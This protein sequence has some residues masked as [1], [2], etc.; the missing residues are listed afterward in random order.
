MVLIA[1]AAA[2]QSALAAGKRGVL[3][4]E[5]TVEG[6][7][8]WK[9]GQ[10]WS[11][12]KIKERFMSEVAVLSEGDLESFNV[13]APDYAE[14]MQA[15]A[16]AIEARRQQI[17]G[18]NARRGAGPDQAA[19]G[20]MNAMM[21]DPAKMMAMQQKAEACN[22]D[23]ACL[24]NLAMEVMA[25]SGEMGA[26]MPQVRAIDAQC[27][28]QKGKAYEACIE[29]LGREQSRPP[30]GM[31]ND[32]IPELAEPEERYRHY[33][34]H[35]GCG[36]KADSSIDHDGK[37]QMADVAGMYDTRRQFR[38]GGVASAQEVERLCLST[39]IVVDEKARTFFLQ[40]WPASI[41][42]VT[43]FIH[44]PP[45]PPITGASEIGPSQGVTEW[46]SENLRNAAFTGSRSTVLT[47]GTGDNGRRLNITMKWSFKP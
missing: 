37:G 17:E 21:A 33:F 23:E 6:E 34:P 26:A 4:V 27:A 12:L 45:D 40:A 15:R 1:A 39:D 32:D 42:K 5:I 13:L 8:K 7:E 35:S 31:A 41:I 18:L 10:D 9:R 47:T 20:S 38:G 29:R 2:T 46:V 14:K 43:S 30:A 25:A 44:N 19:R 16:A 3:T 24:R 28:A 22:G 11:H 36:A